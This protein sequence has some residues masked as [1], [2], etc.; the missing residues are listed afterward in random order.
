MK[1]ICCKVQFKLRPKRQEG[2]IHRKIR[3]KNILE[4]EQNVKYPKSPRRKYAWLVGGI[5]SRLM[6]G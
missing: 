3:E 2:T 4:R 5:E 6:S 1:K